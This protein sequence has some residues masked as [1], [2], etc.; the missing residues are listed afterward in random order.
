MSEMLT[1][2]QVLEKLHI[3]DFSQLSKAN[4]MPF[5]SLLPDMDPEVAKKALEQYPDFAS[6]ALNVMQEYKGILEKALED[7][8]EDSKACYA[9]YNQVME[10]LKK[11]LE[12]DDL[13]FEE[14]KYII[15]QMTA[16][17]DKVHVK[18]REN[19]SFRMNALLMAGL[20]AYI[21]FSALRSFFGSNSSH[22]LL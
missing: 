13:S 4:M 8:S 7:N 22:A 5:V 10:S 12:K 14:R 2:G 17:A 21:G 18:T 9:A 19:L 15:E 11:I 20:V 3:P 1:E 6:N 16:V